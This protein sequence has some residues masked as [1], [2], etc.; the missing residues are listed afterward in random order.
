MTT[1]SYHR[2]M[3]LLLGL[4]MLTAISVLGTGCRQYPNC[5]KDKHCEKFEAR[6]ERGTP[7]CVDLACGEC[8][9]DG[10]CEVGERCDVRT[11]EPIP[12]YC[13]ESH[14]CPSP[15][16]CRDNRCGPEC[17]FDADCPDRERCDNGACVAAQCTT[18]AHC[19]AGERCE[20]Y[21]CVNATAESTAPC[22][23]GQFRP[24]YFDFDEYSITAEARQTM[25][26][27]NLV[28]FENNTT[29]NVRIEGHCDERGTNEYNM[30]LGERRARATKRFLTDNGVDDDRL[31]TI[32][33]GEERPADPR[34]NES[35]WGLNRRA[36]LVWR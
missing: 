20:N 4:V 2:S 14:P 22:G 3:H 19:A 1:T 34:H 13:D 32:S 16:V 18:D 26:S 30:A 28:C 33:Y 31:S 27:W 11:C 25:T 23:N 5:R 35:A 15:Q 24:V 9:S 12:G 36:E 10:D 8:R 6:Q 29:G 21:R 17:R 7:Y